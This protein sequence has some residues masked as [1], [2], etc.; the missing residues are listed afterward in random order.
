[1]EIKRITL[2]N[3]LCNTSS[4]GHIWEYDSIREISSVIEKDKAYKS[5]KC[6]NCGM[7]KFGEEI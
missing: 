6:I 4:E 2:G 7:I 5:Y 3:K 1:M